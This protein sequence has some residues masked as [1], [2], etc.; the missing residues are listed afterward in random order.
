MRLHETKASRIRVEA[1]SNSIPQ[2]RIGGTMVRFHGDHRVRSPCA[3]QNVMIDTRALT[4]AGSAGFNCALAPAALEMSRSA[5]FVGELR[6]AHAWTLK[7]MSRTGTWMKFAA[8][9]H[10]RNDCRVERG[11]V[12]PRTFP[13]RDMRRDASANVPAEEVAPFRKP[14][15][16]QDG[17]ASGLI[18]LQSV[19]S[20]SSWPRPR[21]RYARVS[22]RRPRSRRSRCRSYIQPV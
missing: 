21:L 20:S 7:V 14:Y 5:C 12:S 16:P 13:H 11:V 2:R 19:R 8:A 17:R 4:A 1:P 10:R 9:D 22:L 15:R 6:L 3:L 18:V